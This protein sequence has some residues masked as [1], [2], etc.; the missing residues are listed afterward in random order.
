MCVPRGA[1]VSNGNT[2][3]K[4]LHHAHLADKVLGAVA[5][6]RRLWEREVDAH[7]AAV[8][9]FGFRGFDCCGFS[10]VLCLLFEGREVVGG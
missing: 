9:L 4:H 7:D 3:R 8:R 5:D 6:G 10:L 2:E 1:V